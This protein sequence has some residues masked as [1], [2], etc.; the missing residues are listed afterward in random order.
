MFLALRELRHAKLRYALISLIMILIAWLVLFVTGLASGL[1]S[2]NAASIQYSSADYLL[3]SKDGDQKITRSSLSG[4]S[5]DDIGKF[6]QKDDAAPVSI[7]MSTVKNEN[8]KIDVAFFAIDATSFL[9]PQLVEGKMFSN[10]RS[11][12]VIVDR[13]IKEEGLLLGD[14]IKD[15]LSGKTF[16]IVGFS[17]NQTFSHSPVVHMNAK[18]WSHLGRP[19]SKETMNAIALKTDKDTADKIEK[20]YSEIEAVEKKQALKGIP[21][22]QEEQGSLLMMIIFL[23]IIAAFVLAVF[24]YVITIQKMN[25]FG[26]LK[27]IGAKTGYLAKNILYQVFLLSSVSLLISN[28]LTYGVSFM[29]PAS[30][31]FVLSPLLALG[32]SLLFL[33]VAL[34]GSVLSLYQVAKIDAIEA[35]GRAA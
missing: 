16:T 6:V 13:S 12:E 4:Q 25:Q 14:K 22:Y 21:G 32:C 11:N 28:G 8:K 20:S 24:F 7:Q 30:L 33:G 15:E 3:L 10:D 29:L 35:I 17:K 34:L 18:T 26:V 9:K 23:F 19:Y 1:S 2:D 5:L 31:P 27:A